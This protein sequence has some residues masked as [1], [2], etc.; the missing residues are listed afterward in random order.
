[1]A[2]F[3]KR[4]VSLMDKKIFPRSSLDMQVDNSIFMNS[5]M[6]K[7]VEKTD[8]QIIEDVVSSLKKIGRAI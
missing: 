5:I 6:A 3:Y 1:M 4:E 7:P 2:R 8:E